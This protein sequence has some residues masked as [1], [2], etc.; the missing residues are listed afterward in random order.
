VWSQM[1]TPAGSDGPTTLWQWSGG[2]WTQI[3]PNDLLVG[4]PIG[5][6]DGSGLWSF[7][8]GGSVGGGAAAET[9]LYVG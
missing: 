2:R 4:G 3:K 7:T 5:A 1:L 8:P 6:A 9:E